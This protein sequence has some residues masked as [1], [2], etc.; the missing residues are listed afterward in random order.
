MGKGFMDDGL[1]ESTVLVV[2][3]LNLAFR[4]LHRGSVDFLEEYISTVRSLARSYKCGR[5]VI[6]CDW[7]NSTYRKEKLPIY[8]AQRKEK[9]EQQTEEEAEKFRLFFEEYERV[10]D[11]LQASGEVVLRFRGVEADDIAGWI[12]ENKDELG[13]DKIWLVSTDKDWDQLVQEDVNRFS[14]VTRKET[15]LD[16]WHEHYDYP[17]EHF[18]DVKVMHGDTG[19]NIP[20]IDGVG[21]K[22]AWDLTKKYGSL[23]DLAAS[24]PLSGTA[25]YVKNLNEQGPER[26]LLNLEVMDLRTFCEEAIGRENIAE[27]RHLLDRTN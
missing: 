13:M 8:K 9:I 17:P 14:Y 6:T 7:G 4:W 12:V 21:P 24:L 18:L 23:F 26:L 1:Q 10:I 27:M 11:S 5:L 20:G 22:R 19:D 2:D 25:Q 15:R 3:S 16:N